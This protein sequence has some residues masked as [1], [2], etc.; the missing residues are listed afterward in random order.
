MLIALVVLVFFLIVL[1]ASS[2]RIVRPYERGLVERLGKFKR[3]V[4]AGVHFIIPFFERMIKVDMREKVIDVPPQEVITRDNVVVTVDAVIYYEIT[5]A[6]RV[7][8]NVSNFEMATIKLA[9]TN[10]RNVIGELELD[11]TLTSRERIN[12]K[13]RTVLDEATDK[14][15]VRIT[16]VEI[17]KIDP[18][19]DITD[20]MSK[21]MKAE[22]TKR[23][24]ILEAEGYKQAEILKAEGQ[25]NAAILRAEGEAEA[26]KRVAEANMQKLI[27]EARGQAEAIKL[28]F[29]AI[30]EGNPTK[31]LL[32]VRYLET[33][34]E[35]AN[36]Q[37]TKIFLP[38]EASS[39]LAS[40]GAIS[41]IFK[42][43]ENKRDEK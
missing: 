2:I 6:Y 32:T 16:R 5:D 40:L 27:L 29:N 21:Q 23:A 37:A 31:D 42:K 34:K 12:M 38:F 8:Y 17:K 13:L 10:L 43:E 39:I 9:Q 36:G 19:Q 30:H 15:G 33:L 11:Q 35:M 20:A 18:P 4:G 26:I 7:V 22:R 24:A 14:W 25:K 41:E 3:E 28:V 1:A